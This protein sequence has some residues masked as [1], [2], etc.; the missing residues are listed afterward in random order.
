MASTTEMKEKT[1]PK[2]LLHIIRIL[3]YNCKILISE[4]LMFH[5]RHWPPNFPQQNTYNILL[6]CCKI[7]IFMTFVIQFIRMVDFLPEVPREPFGG[8]K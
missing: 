2:Q 3:F 4:N 1:H 8:R 5:Y 7:G 6:C